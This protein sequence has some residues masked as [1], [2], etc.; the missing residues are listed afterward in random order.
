[1]ICRGILV[2]AVA[3][4]LMEVWSQETESPHYR[5]SRY[6]NQKVIYVEH[7]RLDHS[8]LSL[9][10]PADWISRCFVND[11]LVSF[12]HRT[13]AGCTLEV[14]KTPL[15]LAP[16]N[17]VDA[18]ILYEG[19][20]KKLKP[21]NFIKDARARGI[22]DLSTFPQTYILSVSTNDPPT[23]MMTFFIQPP[24]LYSIHL[25]MRSTL[26]GPVRMDYDMVLRSISIEKHPAPQAPAQPAPSTPAALTNQPPAVP[27]TE[28]TR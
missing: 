12:Q 27:S 6:A 9:E 23:R 14:R 18:L 16:T 20:V 24:D 5:T 25:D 10:S 22:K 7:F 28:T 13:I 19:E 4:F 21:P 15:T 8:I 1:M 26:V 3:V 11:T 2:L 17:E